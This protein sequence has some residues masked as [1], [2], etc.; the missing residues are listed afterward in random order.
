MTNRQLPERGREPLPAGR[1]A[2]RVPTPKQNPED[3]AFLSIRGARG[4]TR[5][6][7]APSPWRELCVMRRKA[8]GRFGFQIAFSGG[9]SHCPRMFTNRFL[10]VAVVSLASVAALLSADES[11]W[12]PLFNGNDLD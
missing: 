10:A 7:F 2:R 11:G 6:A 1:V 8:A 12:K 4:A 5:H 3:G 9:P